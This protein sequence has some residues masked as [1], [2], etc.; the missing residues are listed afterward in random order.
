MNG[1]KSNS[2]IH[3]MVEHPASR[4]HNIRQEKIYL[5]RENSH[6][7]MENSQ[8][9]QTMRARATSMVNSRHRHSKY[10]Q[11]DRHKYDEILEKVQSNKA[12]HMYQGVP[13]KDLNGNIRRNEGVIN[14]N[15][16]KIKKLDGEY[17]KNYLT[18]MK[19]ESQG[20]W[21]YFNQTFSGVP[22]KLCACKH[23]Q[24]EA[25][26]RSDFNMNADGTICS[27]S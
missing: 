26:K 12:Y 9:R 23:D 22:P 6:L 5:D 16:H 15:N 7:D 14:R 8:L 13:M 25:S 27:S 18:G 21:N 3:G 11:H 4:L 2:S 24:N 1:H 19:H 10:P 20:L 17:K